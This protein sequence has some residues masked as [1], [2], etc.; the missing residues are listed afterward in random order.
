M[1]FPTGK[2]SALRIGYELVKLYCTGRFNNY[3][4]G[5][6]MARVHHKWLAAGQLSPVR[7]QV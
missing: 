7:P 2:R 1:S 3:N 4:F 5:Y 6:A